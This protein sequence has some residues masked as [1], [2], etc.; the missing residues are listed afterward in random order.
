MDKKFDI[1]SHPNIKLTAD[2]GAVP[3]THNKQGKYFRKN[4]ANKFTAPD[5][6]VID[7]KFIQSSGI[8]FVDLPVEPETEETEQ[9]KEKQS[10]IK[11]IKSKLWR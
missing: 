9:P 6:V 10:L 11:K 1:L 2:G 3:Y 7:E 4:M 5:D 8:S